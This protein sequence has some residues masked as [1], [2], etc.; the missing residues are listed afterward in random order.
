MELKL[1]IVTMLNLS[2]L[3]INK[4]YFD[5]LKFWPKQLLFLT[6]VN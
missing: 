4:F 6:E 5:H 3:H 2:A 1:D